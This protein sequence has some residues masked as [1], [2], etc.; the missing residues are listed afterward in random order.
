MKR[1][2]KDISLSRATTQLR[3]S[4]HAISEQFDLTDTELILILTETTYNL[5]KYMV[6][7]E[8]QSEE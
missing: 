3:L 2:S 4:V 6:R 1:N 5:T 7:E 8:R